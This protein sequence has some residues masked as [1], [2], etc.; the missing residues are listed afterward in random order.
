MMHG[1]RTSGLVLAL[2]VLVSTFLQCRADAQ[3]PHQQPN[4][5]RGNIF[6]G[7]RSV[8]RVLEFYGKEADLMELIREIQWPATE[9]GASMAALAK[10]LN[11]RGIYTAAVDVDPSCEIVWDFPVIVHLARNDYE[12]FVVWLPPKSAGS[13]PRIWDGPPSRA[14]VLGEF[15]SLR[16]GPLL[17][18]SDRPI[19]DTVVVARERTADV[20]SLGRTV[21]LIVLG[22]VSFFTGFTITGARHCLRESE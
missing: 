1:A 2:P 5:F 3:Q 21:L 7:P 17:V 11:S 18:T 13:A 8:Q 9:Q 22:C 6:C 10:A 12:H 19:P 14:L 16:T 20:K 15:N 4:P